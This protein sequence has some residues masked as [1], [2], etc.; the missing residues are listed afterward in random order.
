MIINDLPIY[1][2]E[3]Y[4]P[5]KPLLELKDTEK[6][7]ES[8]LTQQIRQRFEELDKRDAPTFEN[9]AEMAYIISSFM[10]GRQQWQKNYFSGA[11]G[12]WELVAGGARSDPNKIRSVNKMQFQVSQMLEDL[13]SSNPDYE[14]EDMFKSY[15]HEK[16]VRASKAVWNYYEK[17]FYTP[18][19]N[20]EQALSLITAGTALEELVYD[21]SAQSVKAF[22]EIWGE[23]Q[24]VIDPGHGECLSCSLKGSPQDFHQWDNV[25]Q[26]QE[27][28]EITQA[29][30][31]GDPEAQAMYAQ[32]PLA[33]MAQCPSCGSFDVDL[34]FEEIETVPTVIGLE[35][36]QLG[37]FRLNNLPIQAVRYDVG[38]RPEESSYFIDK[39]F[40]S[41]R[42]VKQLFGDVKIDTGT[43]TDTALDYLHRMPRIAAGVGGS[44]GEFGL[45]SKP[46]ESTMLVRMSLSAE[47]MSDIEIPRGNSEERQ[48]ISGG[49]LPPGQM[50]ADLCPDGGTIVGFGRMEHIYG[51]YKRHHSKSISSMFYF[52]KP[53]SGTGRGAEDLTEIQK[54]VNRIDAQQVKAVDGAAPGYAFVEGAVDEKHIAQIGFPNARIPV[55]REFFNMTK[56]IDS[57]IRQFEPQKVAPQFFAYATELDKLMQMTAHVVN[58]SG[59]VYGADNRTAT[60]AK[61]LEA[62]AQAITIPF[63]Q[64]KAG[65]RKGTI[66]NLLCG[67]KEVF[68]EVKRSFASNMNSGKYIAEVEVTGDKINPDIEFVIVENSMIPQNYYV[69]KADYMA[70]TNAVATLGG[71]AEVKSTDPRMLSKLSKVFGVDI[72]E[73]EYEHITDICRMRMSESFELAELMAPVIE[74]QIATQAAQA[75]ANANMPM[76]SGESALTPEQNA[77]MISPSGGTDQPP[78]LGMEGGAASAFPGTAPPNPVEAANGIYDMLFESLSV[79]IRPQE[80]NLL[81]KAE[82]YRDFLD[83]HEGLQL[84]PNE[85]DIVFELIFKHQEMDRIALATTD[86]A[87][88]MAMAAA[89]LPNAAMQMKVGQMAAMANGAGVMPDSAGANQPAPAKK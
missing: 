14:P 21:A 36:Y 80:K 84:S 41:L 52:S 79:P 24:M 31:A 6:P 42:K 45:V 53:L 46:K 58:M 30:K 76:Q 72:G 37:E 29:A 57:F 25:G 10:Q 59:S 67:Y 89:N 70:F 81:V 74:E 26:G 60:G 23:Q 43:F 20:S 87:N 88:N 51:I 47:E 75:Q 77:S 28:A 2:G 4:A 32:M 82:W 39:Q 73:D 44:R 55:R 38:K 35:Q 64:S 15:K 86:A 17:K 11:G 50:L 40:F 27:Y 65:G 8:A 48:T 54:R 78:N 3:N 18:W 9:I 49:E 22:K 85:R 69:R 63:L 83:S 68:S 71:F 62:T 12:R 33:S 34:L 66:R 13:I 56:Q 1:D 5:V 7:N 19:F 61:I 16:E